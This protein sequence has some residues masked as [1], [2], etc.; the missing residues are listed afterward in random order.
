MNKS[1]VALVAARPYVS[2][3]ANAQLGA[4]RA[5]TILG[6]IDEAIAELKTEQEKETEDSGA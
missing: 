1:Y 4:A 6:L 3:A 5:V 2:A